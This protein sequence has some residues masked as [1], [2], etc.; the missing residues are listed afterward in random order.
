M[1]HMKSHRLLKDLRG[2][3]FD[4]EAKQ[5]RWEILVDFL[6]IVA[7]ACDKKPTHL[8]GQGRR[9]ET[10]LRGVEETAGRHGLRTLRT[11]AMAEF[12]FWPRKPNYETEFFKWQREVDR[13]PRAQQPSVLWVFKD[14]ALESVIARTV[15]GDIDASAALGYPECCVRCHD[16]LG[17]KASEM[18]VEGYKREYG[19]KS[20]ED[21]IR[22]SETNAKVR[23]DLV[24]PGQRIRQSAV[25]FPFVQFVACEHCLVEKNSPAARANR[26]AKKLARN[27]SRFFHDKIQKARASEYPS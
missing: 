8:Q 24:Y 27:L 17:V 15:S 10:F 3:S 4:F 14:P 22:L 26:E 18:L 23:L 6:E 9:S 11:P 20:V 5:S 25:K 16:E 19:A 2:I 12:L 13:R 7:V 1:K 21:L